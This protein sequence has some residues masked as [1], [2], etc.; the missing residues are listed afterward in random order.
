MPDDLPDAVL[1]LYFKDGAI[2]FSETSYVTISDSTASPL[3]VSANTM[4]WL[5]HHGLKHNEIFG[6]KFNYAILPDA[7]FGLKYLIS[8]HFGNCGKSSPTILMKLADMIYQKN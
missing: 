2:I 1:R 5:F 8:A 6:K 3:Q 7:V 4:E